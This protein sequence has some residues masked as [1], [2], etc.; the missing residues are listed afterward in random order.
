MPSAS[1][2]FDLR[3]PGIPGGSTPKSAELGSGLPIRISFKSYENCLPQA[4]QTTAL[5][6]RAFLLLAAIPGG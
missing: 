5:P 4:R 3:G 6:R 1:L 2:I